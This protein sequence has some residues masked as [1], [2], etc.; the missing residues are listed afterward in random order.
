M[1]VSP[2]SQSLCHPQTYTWTNLSSKDE[3][4]SHGA[5]TRQYL[6]STRTLRVLLQLGALC[7]ANVDSWADSLHKQQKPLLKLSVD[8]GTALILNG[9]DLIKYK[10]RQSW[11]LSA[12][13]NTV[14]YQLSLIRH[15]SSFQKRCGF[16]HGV[17]PTSHL[18]VVVSHGVGSSDGARAW[19]QVPTSCNHAAWIHIWV[20][21]MLPLLPEC[22]HTLAESCLSQVVH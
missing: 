14:L 22:P 7:W 5:K 16:A 19:E 15:L 17:P 2:G 8:S 12:I 10:A 9:N 1:P 13:P 3:S 6:L 20:P 11:R 18:R 21:V 4:W